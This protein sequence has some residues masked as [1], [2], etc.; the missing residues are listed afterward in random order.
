MAAFPQ[1]SQSIATGP[2]PALLETDSTWS[3]RKPTHLGVESAAVSQRGCVLSN[4]PSLVSNGPSA[5]AGSSHS[6]APPESIREHAKLERLRRKLGEEV[7]ADAVFTQFPSSPHTPRTIVSRSPK[8]HARP[9]S[10]SRTRTRTSHARAEDTQSITISIGSDEGFQTVTLR[11]SAS[12]VRSPHHRSHKPKGGYHASALPPVPHI[13]S[14]LPKSSDRSGG[15]DDDSGLIRPRQ[16]MAAG[17]KIGGSDFKAARRA[18]R[19]GRSG[20]GEIGEMVEM[21]GF[22]GGGRI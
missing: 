9:R 2:V 21:M 17:S 10:R 11:P 22:L 18:K 15:I 13:S 4:A 7:P 20:H 5:S 6:D 3:K 14:H 1:I 19:E 12:H 8:T 16:Q